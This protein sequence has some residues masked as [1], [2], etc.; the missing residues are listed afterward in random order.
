[1]SMGPKD[2]SLYRGRFIWAGEMTTIH[3]RMQVLWDPGTLP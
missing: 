1:M 3:W 2:P